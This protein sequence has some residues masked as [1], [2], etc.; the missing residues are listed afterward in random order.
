MPRRGTFYAI[1]PDEAERLLALVGN[2]AELAKECMELYTIERQR[3]RFISPVDHSWEVLH[4]CLGDAAMRDVGAGTT[5]LAWCVLGGKS[6]HQGKEFIVC[7]V[8]PEQ[9]AQVAEELDD[10]EIDWLVDRYRTLPG[11]GYTG[12]F[13]NENFMYSWDYFTNVRNLYSKAAADGRG[14]VFVTDQ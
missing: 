2:D 6:L 14:V 12:P 5:P 3:M 7:Y 11:A 10:I 9:T 1:T 8:T 13:D 4:R